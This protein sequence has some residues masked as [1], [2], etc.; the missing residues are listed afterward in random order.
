M[1][2][3]Q[4][5]TRVIGGR[6]VQRATA[7]VGKLVIRFDD[8]STMQVKSAGIT[9]MFP[10]GGTIKAVQEDGASFT[11]QLEDHSTIRVELADPGASVAV[12]DKNNE[13]EYLG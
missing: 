4:K 8:Q 7:E 11:L 3:K 9:G 10:P 12:R 13:V 1:A 5:L 6:T 2:R